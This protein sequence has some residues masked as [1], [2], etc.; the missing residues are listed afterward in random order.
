MEESKDIRYLIKIFRRR[1]IAFFIPATLVFLIITLIALLLPPIYKATTTILIEEQQIPPEYVKST[2]TSY[3]EQRLQMITQQIMSY[4]R[5]ME[6]INKFNLYPEMRNKCTM[7]EIVDKMRK[8]IKLETINT[9]VVNKRTGRPVSATI[10]FTLSYEGKNPY[11]VQQVANVLASLYLEYNLKTREQQASS[12]TAFLQHELK[13]L[14]KYITKLENK[15][16]KFKKE[17]LGELPEFIN[18]NLQTIQRL[19]DNL[20]QIEAEIRSLQERK[21]YL[22]GQLALIQPFAPIIT[23]D[24]KTIMNPSERLKYLRL[25]LISLQSTLSPNHPDIIKLKKEIKA[26]EAQVGQT[27]ETLEKIKQLNELQT[28]LADLKSKLGPKHPDVIKLQKN[29]EILSKELEDIDPINA[30]TSKFDVEKPDNPAYINILTQIGSIDVQIKSLKEE[31]K[32]IKK[33]IEEYQNKLENTPSVEKEY[34]ALLI[35]YQNA[36]N[37]YNELMS[38]LMEARVAQEMEESQRGERFTIIDPAQLPEKPYKPKRLAI[39]LI[40]FVLAIGAGIAS[41]ATCE[42]M[43]HSIKTAEELQQIV[44]APILSVLPYIETQEEKNARRKKRFLIVIL[45]VSI[46]IML[47]LLFHYFV[48]PLDIF[49]MKFEQKITRLW[50]QNF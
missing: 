44:S 6:I 39:I 5:L 13:E 20:N 15:I 33:K 17:H 9:E 34:N 42:Y 43:D 18:I 7:E 45:G 23:E 25:K 48:M 31:E 37:K 4:S 47:L 29:I 22:E 30:S 12:T 50:I 3:V 36:R 21:V 41:V 26:L 27:D 14:K 32:K 35:D 16:S 38:K 19:N 46:L 1:K 28:K 8:D 24:G 49:W 11:K 10:A 2:V 40:G